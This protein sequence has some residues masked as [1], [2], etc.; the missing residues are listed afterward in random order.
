MKVIFNDIFYKEYVNDAASIAG[1]M[2]II[3][4]SFK[5]N[6]EYII[7]QGS[8]ADKNDLKL[9]HKEEYI[10]SIEQ[11]DVL[12]NSAV[13]AAGCSIDAAKNAAMNIPAFACIR[14]PGH[15]AYS[16]SAWGHCYFNNI[17]IAIN[18]INREN[19][20]NNIFLLDFDAHT[21]DGT[22]D[23]L[24]KDKNINIKIL[25]PTAATADEY[26]A[27]IKQYISELGRIDLIAV[28][29]GFD[30]YIKDVGKKLRTFDYYHIG[31]ILSELAKK[32]GHK[33]KFAVL[34]GGY[35]LPDLGKNVVSFCD[36][37]LI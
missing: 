20:I 30:S 12:F 24:L 35:Y 23:I 10:S 14:P 19:G 29:A 11:N 25:N 31:S 13:Y 7:I 27:E 1:R 3:I 33:R 15:H 2:E 28:S 8:K 4:E 32:N 9:C 26:I 34:E 21:G 6:E 17:A 5:H 16:N 36:S 37:F 18:K 22:R